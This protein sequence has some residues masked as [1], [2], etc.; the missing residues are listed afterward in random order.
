MLSSRRILFAAIGSI[1]CVSSAV[2]MP[3]GGND[4]NGPRLISSVS[5]ST[6]E[7]TIDGVGARGSELVMRIGK[8]E[9]TRELEW[10]SSLSGPFTAKLEYGKVPLGGKRFGKGLVLTVKRGHVKSVFNI[11][12]AKGGPVPLGTVRFRNGEKNGKQEPII[13]ADNA[14]VIVADIVQEDGTTV[15]ITML[16]RSADLISSISVSTTAAT[17]D[18]VGAPGSEFVMR[19]GKTA[20]TRELEW[21]STLSGPF[22]AKLESGDVPLGGKRFGKGLVLTVKHSNVKSVFNISIGE[23]GPVPVGTVRFRNFDP[24]RA[25]RLGTGQNNG[26]DEPIARPDGVTVVVA[27]IVQEDGTKVPITMLLRGEAK[28]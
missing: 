15:P 2:A 8:T 19:I 25:V 17:I 21:T 16:L 26:Q 4:G 14:S 18:G 20:L 7:A 13:L 5:A 27:D 9:L 28:K 12:N 24:A 11:G 22:T 23:G 3:P 6:T 1:A 10:K